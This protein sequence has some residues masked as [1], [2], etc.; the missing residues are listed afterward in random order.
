[1]VAQ[2]LDDEDD[3]AAEADVVGGQRHGRQRARLA[4]DGEEQDA[5]GVD[6]RRLDRNEAPRPAARARVEERQ[7]AL[8]ASQ[9]VPPFKFSDLAVF[10]RR[11]ISVHTR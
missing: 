8:P 11:R 1:M 9:S 7:P 4:R 10:R 5:A 3:V 6:G 2:V